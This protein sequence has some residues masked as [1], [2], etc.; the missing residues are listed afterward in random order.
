MRRQRRAQLVDAQST[1]G[2]RFVI[3]DNLLASARQTV[4][5]LLGQLGPH[6][7]NNQ[8]QQTTNTLDETQSILTE[9]LE[10]GP[11]A[12]TTR[13]KATK[14]K[15]TIHERWC[16]E[17]QKHIV[18]V[19]RLIER[20]NAHINAVTTEALS[21]TS[22]F[23]TEALG[24]ANQALLTLEDTGWTLAALR[25][26]L[27]EANAIFAAAQT[28]I[29]SKELI[30]A[31]SQLQAAI[32][33]ANTIAA[34]AQKL[35]QRIE[36]IRRQTSNFRQQVQLLEHSIEQ[37][38]TVLPVLRVTYAEACCRGFSEEMETSLL[39]RIQLDSLLTILVAQTVLNLE[40]L[41]QADAT[42]AFFVETLNRARVTCDKLLGA[43]NRLDEMVIE[44]EEGASQ[45]RTS[46]NELS[47][48]IQD[49]EGDQKNIITTLSKASRE[50]GELIN[51]LRQPQPDPA[52]LQAQLRALQEFINHLDDL[53][54]RIDDGND[55]DDDSLLTIATTSLSAALGIDIFS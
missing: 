16:E 55:D 2:E 18:R 38:K 47:I 42:I 25:G 51:R 6:D 11:S 30:T 19:Q 33:Q 14:S 29:R 53:S 39:Q 20:C 21:Q 52:L 23:A 4:D 5:V 36:E 35:P 32:T 44:L 31:A 15:V 45:L 8:R 26:E 24:T 34:S 22:H 48:E 28:A 9:Y 46:I 17:L 27:A 40:T 41:A 54:L 10:S 49:R 1:A 3:L 12:A 37:A 13:I 50:T 43:K 7:A